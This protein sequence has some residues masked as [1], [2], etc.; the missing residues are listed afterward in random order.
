[1]LF[2]ACTHTTIP[3]TKCPLVSPEPKHSSAIIIPQREI[4]IKCHFVCMKLFHSPTWTYKSITNVYI[5]PIH[6]CVSCTHFLCIV[7]IIRMRGTHEGIYTVGWGP[8]FLPCQ[9][10]LLALFH[11]AHC[12]R[13]H[14]YIVGL[15]NVDFSSS[16]YYSD[17]HS[18]WKHLKCEE[19]T[20]SI[21][22]VYICL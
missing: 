4:S 19:K 2:Y 18:W 5:H 12:T 21:F 16:F 8:V 15:Y 10:S 7:C 6:F 22:M 11:L 9:G 14:Y 13:G 3:I 20:A 1:M 17:T